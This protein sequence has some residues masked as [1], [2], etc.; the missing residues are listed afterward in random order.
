[1]KKKLSKIKEFLGPVPTSQLLMSFGIALFLAA[2]ALNID[3]NRVE[4]FFYDFRMRLKG[5]EAPHADIMLLTLSES[6]N[7][8]SVEAQTRVLKNLLAH[9]PKAI[10]YLN[11]FDPSEVEARPA[12]AEE[13]VRLAQKGISQ[14]T[15]VY[16]GTEVDLSGEVTPPFPMSTLPHSPSILHKDG[17]MF[18]EDKVMRRALL[19]VFDEPSVHFRA[20]FPDLSK[21]QLMAGVADLRGSYYYEPA[22]SW[23]MLINYPESTAASSFPRISFQE[24]LLG[25]GTERVAGKIILV[26]TL[27][28]DAMNDYAYTP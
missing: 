2:A 15:R 19:T 24:A 6:D 1:M 21:E 20:A 27:R 3:L 7:Y 8:T 18:G 9:Q 26:E 22:D 5:A 14:G 25:R 11:K 28:R 4:A 23:H 12:E 17:T 10:I 16:L 13:F